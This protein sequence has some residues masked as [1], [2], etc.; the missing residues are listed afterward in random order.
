MNT[1]EVKQ[2]L[3][4]AL[5]Q[6]D[7]I[8]ENATANRD[9]LSNLL[10]DISEDIDL[11]VLPEAFATGFTMNAQYVSEK[12][13]G[14]TV[15]WMKL[16]ARKL[17]LA[18]CGS[19]FIKE[20]ESTYNRFL[21]VTQEGE[22]QYYN[23]R[24]LFSIGGENDHYISGKSQVVIH[25]KGWKIFP[26]ICYDLRFP[27]WSRNSMGYDMLINVANWPAPRREVWTTLLKARAIE[28]QCYVIGVNRVGVD[29]NG[30]GH[31][32]DSQL[33]DFKGNPVEE[34]GNGEKVHY[35]TL[36]KTALDT[37][38]EKFNTLNDRDEF[39]IS[40]I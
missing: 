9:I 1:S 7:P 16:Q 17:K 25:Y 24:H 33:I 12:M 19:H 22:V 37:F 20:E 27:V 26:Q 8:W 31:I 40:E 4:I 6:F 34:A 5:V 29:G 2:Q 3:K 35:V 21:F 15:E 36:H 18:I 14:P 39:N 28:N 10:K 38:R 11:L 32:G 23:K 30:I 13:D